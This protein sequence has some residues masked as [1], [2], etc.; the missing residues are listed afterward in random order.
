LAPLYINTAG[1]RPTATQSS[2]SNAQDARPPKD[3]NSSIS[4]HASSPKS[5]QNFYKYHILLVEDNIINQKFCRKILE[6]AGCTVHIANHGIEA[7]NF[8]SKTT[9]WHERM[10]DGQIIGLSVI[11]MDFAMPYLDGLGASRRIRELEAEGK[12]VGHVPVIGLSRTIRPAEREQAIEAG[13]VKFL[14]LNV[15]ITNAI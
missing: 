15:I 11:L 9:F 1:R 5:F 4:L 7:L 6:N 12:I 14:K 2:N 3:S 8:L 10:N 13:M